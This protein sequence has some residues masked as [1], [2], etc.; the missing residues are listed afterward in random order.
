MKVAT[1]EKFHLRG[2]GGGNQDP[3]D[4]GVGKVRGGKGFFFLSSKGGTDP[5]WH[6]A[7]HMGGGRWK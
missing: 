4:P 5:E 1:L 7:W 2:W 3:G 6:Y